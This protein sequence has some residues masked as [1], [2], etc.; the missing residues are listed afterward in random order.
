MHSRHLATLDAWRK[1]SP[2][3]GAALA[4]RQQELYNAGRA[5]A[6]FPVN[7][8]MIAPVPKFGTAKFAKAVKALQD[9]E[10]QD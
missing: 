7:V 1:F 10:E 2:V 5:E 6:G 8:P 9:S 4:R 3:S